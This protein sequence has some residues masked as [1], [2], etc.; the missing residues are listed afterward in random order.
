VGQD[1]KSRLRR[2][3]VR[4]LE[5][6]VAGDVFPGA[7]ACVSYREGERTRFLT[8]VAGRLCAG[9]PAVVE[10]T[11]YDIASLTKP[12]VAMAALRAVA[13]G[14]VA[15]TSRAQAVVPDVRGGRGGEATLETL[16]THRSGLAAWGGFYL[17]VP[18]AAGS[19]A[20]RRWVLGEVARRHADAPAGRVV[21]SDLGYIIAGEMLAR[22][23]GHPLDQVLARHVTRPLGISAEVFYPGALASE[24]RAHL[25]SRVAPT[26][27]CEWRGC[28]V[29]GEVHDENCVVLGGV[30]GHAGLFG[31][32]QGV[33][34]F[35]REMLDVL[36]GRSDFLPGDLLQRALADPGDGASHRLGWD[37]KST[38]GSS[39][40]RRMS[41]KSFGHLGF[42]GTS[43][44]C[45]PV[46]D[47][48][49]VLLTNRVCPSRA[50]NKI[51]GFRP[52]FH[53][54]VI[55]AFED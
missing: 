53:D 27:R 21:Y 7:S 13:A 34:T 20:A 22:A 3:I 55:A 11:P 26:E 19:P 33:A 45:D 41:L 44:W 37:T 48:V 8:V 4:L 38:D 40:G 43:I 54:G 12:F 39:A 14:E 17:D 5:A 49:V 16:L 25:S 6:G 46:R 35:G 28:L 31:T 10:G 18:H 9:G 30:S 50:N 1:K 23:A 32:A 52:A 15:L 42:T 51:K 24:Q 36:H 47:F 2:E 29:Q